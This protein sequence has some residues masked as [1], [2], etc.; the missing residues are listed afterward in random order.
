MKFP[1]VDFSE[2]NQQYPRSSLYDLKWV[3]E[4]QMGLMFYDWQNLLA[5]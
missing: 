4:N 1:V 5:R 3:L 2:I